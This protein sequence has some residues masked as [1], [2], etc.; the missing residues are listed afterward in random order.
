MT[1]LDIKQ[2]KCK[3]DSQ[4]KFC[5]ELT[6]VYKIFVKL[7]KLSI[8][9]RLVSEQ[10]ICRSFKPIS[11]NFKF[12]QKLKL[13]HLKKV[14][15]RLLGNNKPTEIDTALIDHCLEYP[16]NYICEK[17]FILGKILDD[18]KFSRLA[19]CPMGLCEFNSFKVWNKICES[20]GW[21][22]EEKANNYRWNP[23]IDLPN[24]T[25]YWKCLDQQKH[26]RNL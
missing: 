14:Q 7:L 22:M 16:K 4:A 10:Q 5:P 3:P 24:K 1:L 9:N 15:R 25:D 8:E 2:I 17:V 19:G 23:D 21:K 26:M 13:N 11:N 6:L 18:A 20:I 12:C